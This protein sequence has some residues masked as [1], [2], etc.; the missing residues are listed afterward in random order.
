LIKEFKKYKHLNFDN[1][2]LND[3]NPV[4]KRKVNLRRKVL[5]W[6]F[7]DLIGFIEGLI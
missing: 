3:E 1:I 7:M 4:G 2:F 5:N 6:M